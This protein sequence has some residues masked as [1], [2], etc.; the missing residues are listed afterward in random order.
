M[1]SVGYC[2]FNYLC[3]LIGRNFDIWRINGG[4]IS[5]LSSVRYEFSFAKYSWFQQLYVLRTTFMAH[6]L[7]R[8]GLLYGSNVETQR[9][10]I[11]NCS[12]VLTFEMG[13]VSFSNICKLW[14]VESKDIVRLWAGSARRSRRRVFSERLFSMYSRYGSWVVAFIHKQEVWWARLVRHQCT[15]TSKSPYNNRL[16]LI[17]S[18]LGVWELTEDRFDWSCEFRLRLRIGLCNVARE[19]HMVTG[20]SSK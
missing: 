3:I 4:I 1:F 16:R 19:N 2:W 5:N 15:S 20:C 6:L 18:S 8:L 13:W 11:I 12:S 17:M 14:A 10:I 7:N 9:V